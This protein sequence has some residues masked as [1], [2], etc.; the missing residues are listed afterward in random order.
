MEE[1]T[2]FSTSGAGTIRLPICK[3]PNLDPNIIYKNELK[4]NCR[5]KYKT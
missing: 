1:K 3:Q 2:V 5:S 4:I